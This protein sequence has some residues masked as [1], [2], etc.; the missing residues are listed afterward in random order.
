MIMQ[1]MTDSNCVHRVALDACALT[2]TVLAT[3]IFHPDVVLFLRLVF[4]VVSI[5]AAARPLKSASLAD[6]AEN[7]PAQRAR[8]TITSNFMFTF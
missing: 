1:M 4:H 7:T 2:P 6:V 8:A 5:T 3:L